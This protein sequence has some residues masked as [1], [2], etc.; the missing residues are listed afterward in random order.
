MTPLYYINQVALRCCLSKAFRTSLFHER[1]GLQR[2]FLSGKQ[3]NFLFGYLIYSL[4][5]SVRNHL[6]IIINNCLCCLH[7]VS[8]ILF[9]VL[10]N[11]I[12]NITQSLREIKKIN[13]HVKELHG[14]DTNYFLWKLPKESKER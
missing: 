6:K 5:A 14:K 9:D 10:I 8:Y 7:Q 1:L 2:F 3:C 4:T 12:N 11:R 13:N